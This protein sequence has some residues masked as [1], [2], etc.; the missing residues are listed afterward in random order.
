LSQ[1]LQFLYL[2]TKGWKTTK[3]HKIEIWFVEYDK[4]YYIIS[5]RKKYAHWLQNILHNS[6]ITF[7]VNNKTLEGYARLVD[8]TESELITNVS[9][10]MN[11]KYGW[12][13][14]L[15]VEL[16]PQ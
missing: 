10:L 4:K 1:Q 3:Y 14:G 12:S 7:I 2:I 6:N 9:N 11:K 13:D 8:S 16:D 5:E 15:I